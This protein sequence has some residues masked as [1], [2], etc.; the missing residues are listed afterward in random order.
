MNFSFCKGLI[1]FLSDLI[2]FSVK[3]LINRN[4]PVC[5]ARFLKNL[6]DLLGSLS[7]PVKIYLS[8]LRDL[9]C[10]KPAKGLCRI[11]FW[12]IVRKNPIGLQ[13]SA[14]R[15]TDHGKRQLLLPQKLSQIVSPSSQLCKE[16]FYTP[17]GGKSQ[18]KRPL[19]PSHLLIVFLK[20][21]QGLCFNRRICD[22]LSAKMPQSSA[23]FCACLSWP[24]I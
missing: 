8:I 4:I 17:G 9:F 14:C 21:R 6:Y 19:F 3:G 22:H 18:A 10:Q 1:D 12:H 11:A 13:T 24:G 7:G 15:L 20:R 23:K 5:D 16:I 2:S